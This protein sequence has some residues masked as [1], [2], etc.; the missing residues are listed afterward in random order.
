V[1]FTAPG[2]LVA[3]LTLVY[4][5]AETPELCLIEMVRFEVP[6]RRGGRNA[7]SEVVLAH[8]VVLP[9]PAGAGGG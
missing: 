3:D 4:C 7:P 6:V 1:R 5:E 9:D 2:D 8:H